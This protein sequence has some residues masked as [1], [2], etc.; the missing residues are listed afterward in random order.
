MQVLLDYR[1]YV[2]GGKMGTRYPPPMQQCMERMVEMTVPQLQRHY[3][4][5]DNWTTNLLRE[6]AKGEG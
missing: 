5:P 3:L 2:E 1:C 4:L 6:R